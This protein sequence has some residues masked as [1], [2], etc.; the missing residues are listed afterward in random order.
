M[1]YHLFALFLFVVIPSDF[2]S[3]WATD[4]SKE[5]DLAGFN[6]YPVKEP[7]VLQGDF[8]DDG[9]SDW[10]FQAKDSLGRVHIVFI[11]EGPKREIRFLGGHKD[12]F[13]SE[14]YSWAQVFKKA[15]A[16]EVLWANY[17]DDYRSFDSVP[18]SEKL[19]L[20]YDA[21]Y[22]HLA[23]ACGGGYVYWKD[24]EFHWLQQE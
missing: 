15:E 17:I 4:F 18:D 11:D 23:E 7:R 14:D 5:K 12:P 22:M 10:A 9:F 3:L 20:N 8:F 13:N 1:L 2:L 21:L 6:L 19:I 16:G 24:G